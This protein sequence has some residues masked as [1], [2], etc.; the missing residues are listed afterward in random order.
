FGPDYKD[1]LF[2]CLFNMQK[3]TRHLLEP[4]GA[5]F[6][7]H[8][9]DFMASDNRACEPT[10][11]LEDADGSLLV[12][13]TGGWYKLCC[14]TSQLH[15]PDVLGGIYRIRR[16]GGPKIDDPRYA[17]LEWK[18][19]RPNDVMMRLDD[20][21]PAVRQR[22]I[23]ELSKRGKDAIPALR[24]AFPHPGGPPFAFPPLPDARR[25]V[26][27]SLARIEVPESAVLIR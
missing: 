17:K 25:N 27:W 21:R 26:V 14:P 2:A 24:R 5:T 4:S 20:A 7:S 9:A 15:K 16:A 3:V 19:M 18:L 8:D 11:V 12:I 13:N 23:A 10:D 22:A 6:K 1:N